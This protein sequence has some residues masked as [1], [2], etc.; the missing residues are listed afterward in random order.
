MPIL[1]LLITIASMLI[2]V[3]SMF[4]GFMALLGAIVEAIQG[5]DITPRCSICGCSVNYPCYDE[6]GFGQ[7]ARERSVTFPASSSDWLE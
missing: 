3:A 2:T 5:P 6:C 1:T 4:F 7:A